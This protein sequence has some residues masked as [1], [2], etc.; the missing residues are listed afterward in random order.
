MHV[1]QSIPPNSP[2]TR[3]D[4]PNSME[5]NTNIN[6]SNINN[7]KRVSLTKRPRTKTTP[8]RSQAQ[9]QPAAAATNP[10]ISD[11]ADISISVS[12][13]RLGHDQSE[14]ILT[15]NNIRLNFDTLTIKRQNE[16]QSSLLKDDV[17]KK[18][19]EFLKTMKPTQETLNLFQKI[20]PKPTYNIFLTEL[21][22][23]YGN[24]F[25]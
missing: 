12:L 5:N 16:V 4:S 22:H 18:M 19:L 15:L 8:L 1:S 6:N 17:W 10:P 20:L 3:I 25:G 24:Y 7:T 14:L 23:V 2:N 11:D 21:K 9:I 13:S